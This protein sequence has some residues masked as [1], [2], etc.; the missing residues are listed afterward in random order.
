MKDIHSP[1]VKN[2]QFSK[3]VK[4][5]GRVREFNFR[6]HSDNNGEV[7]FSIDVCD[8]RNN[9]ITFHMH[10]KET[11]W[12]IVPELLPEWILESE[13]NFNQLIEE[14]LRNAS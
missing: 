10:Q 3:L 11:A 6:K 1:Y 7:V 8:N 2:L 5:G 12:K 13:D 9:R 14:E 4:L